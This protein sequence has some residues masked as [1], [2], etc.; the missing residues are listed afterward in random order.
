MNNTA[1]ATKSTRKAPKLHTLA[2]AMPTADAVRATLPDS[3]ECY[4]RCMWSM[5][6]NEGASTEVHVAWPHEKRAV[7]ALAAKGLVTIRKT[8]DKC[9][10]FREWWYSLAIKL[11]R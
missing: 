9:G 1:T 8:N 10:E 4:Q 6:S 5:V 7:E 11:A 3:V 2:K